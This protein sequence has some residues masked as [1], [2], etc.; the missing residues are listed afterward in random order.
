[1]APRL[2]SGAQAVVPG[3]FVLVAHSMG[4]LVARRAAERLGPRLRGLLL[5]DALPETAPVYDTWDETTKKIDRMLAVTQTLSRFPP[6]ARLFSGNV[7]RLFSAGT[8]RTM[9]AEDFTP[10]G[11]AQT[12]EE[13]RAVAAA[14][15]RFRAQPPA[16][17]KCPAIVLSVTRAARGRERQHAAIREHQRRYAESLPDGR[18][19]EV[20]SGHLLQAERPDLVAGRV[21]RLLGHDL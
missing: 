7:R 10:A 16:L 21:R 14:V 19:E 5:A 1:M 18:H 3:D 17:P 13:I 2:R 6:L 11:I 4:G 9:L 8:Y 15:P 12:R 20:D